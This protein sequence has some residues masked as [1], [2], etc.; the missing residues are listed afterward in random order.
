MVRDYIVRKLLQENK[1]ITED[2][3]NIREFQEETKKMR[4]EIEEI[5]TSAKIF[6][7]NKCTY[8]TSILDLP[9][10]HFLCMHSYHLR[11]LG[12]NESECPVCA[13]D[14]RK[15]LEMKKS[16]EVKSEEEEEED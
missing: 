11:C 14:N 6:Q 10:V 3:R 4:A 16:L 9:A 13:P 1:A 15:I 2:E 12:D 8:C 5:K 7:S